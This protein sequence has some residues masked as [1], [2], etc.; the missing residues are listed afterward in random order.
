MRGAGIEIRRPGVRVAWLHSSDSG[1][2]NH[3][4]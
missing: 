4:G 1:F 3:F 2:W